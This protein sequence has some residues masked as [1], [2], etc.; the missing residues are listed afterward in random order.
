MTEALVTENTKY[1]SSYVG[2]VFSVSPDIYLLFSL[3][4]QYYKTEHWYSITERHVQYITEAP[5]FCMREFIH[6]G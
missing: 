1:A 4:P 5:M 3:C 6:F 2:F